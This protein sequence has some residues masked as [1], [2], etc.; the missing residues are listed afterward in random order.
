MAIAIGCTGSS[1]ICT[2]LSLIRLAALSFLTETTYA[3][4]LYGD[5]PPVSTQTS[6]LT[7]ANTDEKQRNALCR[8][9]LF[10]CPQ[11]V[12]GLEKRIC[13]FFHNV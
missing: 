11:S 1:A 8:H 9:N 13:A 2:P 5:S 4:R 3:L 7:L 6:I 12:N 10:P